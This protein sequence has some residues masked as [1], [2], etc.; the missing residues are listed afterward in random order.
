MSDQIELEVSRRD[1]AGKGVRRLRSEGWIPAA[2]Y[3]PGREALNLQVNARALASTLAEAGGSHIISLNLEGVAYPAIVRDVQRDYVRGDLLHVDFYAVS[4]DRPIRTEVP[5][6]FINEP[7][8]VAA[9]EA[10]L[11]TGATFVEMESLPA[12]LPASIQVDLA[13]LVDMDTVI[14]VADLAV[15]PGVTIHTNPDEMIA[16]LSYMREEEEEEAIEVDAEAVEVIG[17][18][19]EEDFEEEA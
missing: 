14:T 1:I 16:T 9:H 4:M 11:V 2:L 10:I 7:P 17:R 18:E 8:L 3:G 13:A 15:P 5:L 19:R 6:E 12:D